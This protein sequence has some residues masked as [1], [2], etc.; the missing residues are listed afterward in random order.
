MPAYLRT[1]MHEEAVSALEMF[2]ESLAA[3]ASDTYRWKWSVI[4][5]HGAVQ[6]F[7]VL[8]LRGSNNFDVLN[9]RSAEIWAQAFEAHSPPSLDEQ[10]LDSMLGLYA[11]A[12]SDR[13]MKF[14][15]S[16]KF[17]PQGTQTP[18]IKALNSLRNGF[19]HFV[20]KRWSIEVGGLPAICS[21]CLDL[22]EFLGWQ[23]GNVM[24]IEEDVEERARR[25]MVD[26]RR[27]IQAL[28]A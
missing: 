10:R 20:P 24:W 2:A 11:K 16:R 22:I 5:L 23:S 12:K 7:L 15:T 6:G 18:S 21:D 26:A 14:V 19:I 9:P 4:A 27:H 8:S 13:M 17:V 1:D 28:P 3:V 25:A